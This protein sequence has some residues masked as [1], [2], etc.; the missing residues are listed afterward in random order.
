MG[1]VI[2]QCLNVGY[3][4]KVFEM[5]LGSKHVLLFSKFGFLFKLDLVNLSLF[6]SKIYFKCFAVPQADFKNCWP[7]NCK[8]IIIA[9]ANSSA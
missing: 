2:N 7:A 9:K 5:K 8:I 3:I 6:V 1:Y 4:E